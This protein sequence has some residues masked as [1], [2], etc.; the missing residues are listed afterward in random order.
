MDGR[1]KLIQI[2]GQ[3]ADDEILADGPKAAIV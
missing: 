1:A 2:Y 3:T